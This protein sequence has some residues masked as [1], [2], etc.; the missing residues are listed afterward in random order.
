MNWLLVF[1]GAGVGGVVRFWL[2]G[3]IQQAAGSGFP[4]GTLTINVTG[5]F[6]LGFLYILLEGTA[7]SAY[8]RVLLGIGFCGGYTTFSTF[9]YE[10]VR[11]MQSGEWNRATAYMTGS[12]VLSLAAMFIGFRIANAI[13]RKA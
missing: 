11:L 4:W 7:A 12:V 3:V 5:S 1:L 6:V 10:A 9:S 8:W 2:G 13:L